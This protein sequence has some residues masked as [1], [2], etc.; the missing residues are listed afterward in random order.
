MDRTEKMLLRKCFD[1]EGKEA[2]ASLKES[3]KKTT[4]LRY[5]EQMQ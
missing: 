1:K 4:R 5:Q 2:T 3:S